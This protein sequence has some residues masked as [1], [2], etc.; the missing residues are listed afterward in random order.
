MKQGLYEQLI[1]KLT[2]DQLAALDPSLFQIGTERLDSEE[3]RKLLST[4]ISAVTRRA[5]KIVREMTDDDEA[6]LA[7]V[8]IC[9]EM[10]S[11]LRNSLDD[12]DLNEWK[13]DEQGELLTF[14]YS[15]LNHIRG[16]KDAKV[17]RPA[18]PLS[19][20]SLFT[21]AHSEPNMMS[22]LQH[23]IVTSDRI[24]LLVSFIKWSGLRILMEQLEHFTENGGQLRVITTTYMEATDY[25]AVA[26]L[27]RLKNTVIQ[28]SYDTDRTRLHAKAYIFRRDTGF[29]TAYVGSSNLS[30][31]ALT[32]GLEWNIKVTEKDSYDV[33]K[34]IEATFES[35]WNDRE[36]KSFTADNEEHQLQLKEALGRKKLREQEE[37]H[38]HFDIHPFDYQ[39]EV[40][41]KLEAERS[42]YGRNHNLLVAATGVGKT[43][44]SAFDY[45]RFAQKNPN[46]RLLFVAH[47][48]EILKQSR[49]TFRF[50]LKDL[51]F[52][53]LHVGGD[54]ARSIDHLFISIQSFNSMKLAH[55]TN[56]DFYDFIIVDEFH[57]AAAP[58]YQALL[59][60]Y[61]PRILLGLT[62]TPERMDGR[63]ILRY[64]DNTI[65][66]E[67]RLTD[68]IDRKLLSPFQY[69]GVTDSVDL[70]HVK[71]SRRG[72]DLK[73]LENLYSN[74]K[75]RVT[76][77]LNS[78][79]KYVTDM[80]QVKGLGFC[81]GV[82]HAEYMA[83]VFQEAGIPS[84]A[85]HGNSSDTDRDQAKIR[86]V[87]GEIRMIFVVDLYNEGVDIPEVNTILF[88]RPTE[89]LTVFLQQLGRGL[90]LAEGKECLTV[91]DFIGQAHKDYNFAD[92]FRA[93]I[94]KTKHSIQNY[95]ENGFSTLPRGSFIQLEKQSK[96]YIL[97]N[98][99]QAT[100]NR[101]SLINKMKYFE[102]DTGLP[103]TLENFVQHHHMSLQEFYGG[104]TGNRTFKGL[105][106]EA[107]LIASFEFANGE[108]LTKRIPALL[109]LNSRR[110]L[111]FLIGCLENGRKPASEEEHL[112]FNMLYYTFYRSE[113]AKQG[114]ES[115]EQGVQ[116]AVSCPEFRDEVLQILKYNYA[117]IDFVDKKNPFPYACPLDVHCKYSTDHILAAFGFWNEEK[118]PAFREGVKYF[119]DKKTD[120]FFITLNKSDKDFSPSTLYED[121]A[122]NERLFHWQ[123]QSRIGEETNTA[124]RYIHHRRTGNRIVLFV[125]EYKDENNYTSPFVF[126]GEAGYVRHEGHKPMSF[127]WHLMEEMPPSLIP[128][129]NKVIV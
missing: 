83:K 16:I 4:Y 33:L 35:Y 29:T 74:N 107:E 42:L 12:E 26:E 34:K 8:R 125:R 40:L 97:K 59:S 89:S 39:K 30:N 49:D 56:P 106:A 80:E 111:S 50:I 94:G 100:L 9:N 73:E 28:I 38:F 58:S 41:E 13:L 121:Y 45:K 2:R 3:A 22:E 118:A 65:A 124:Q 117:H 82:N 36:F 63:D 78:M 27:S 55:I 31:P 68:A 108:S 61:V 91:L 54:R 48:E 95:L 109:G 57:H 21:G 90:R 67:I 10:I 60:H 87:S 114:F 25:K 72:Y 120:I 93:L 5:L 104:R 66:A 105:M 53:E 129:A 96:A 88:L 24:D 77:I 110:L 15:K 101:R 123:T 113:P 98:L 70:T 52:G 75:I 11:T 81:V 20:S 102:G 37:L 51:N 115:I 23:E 79:R 46:A 47:R 18:T 116:S 122:I 1:N 86:L 119:E 76:Q 85:L 43:V 14:V 44:I 103:L 128:A 17:L 126:L 64:F 62:A 84:I 6:V 19:Q 127:V 32:S 71:W 7:Q 99:K 92:K 112:M 69:F